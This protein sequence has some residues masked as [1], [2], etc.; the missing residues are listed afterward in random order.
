MGVSVGQT[1]RHFLALQ[2]KPDRITK[3]PWL[4]Y[5]VKEKKG[6]ARETSPVTMGSN[7]LAIKIL[8]NHTQ[9]ANLLKRRAEKLNNLLHTQRVLSRLN[10]Y[11]FDAGLDY[12]NI[13]VKL[14]N[15]AMQRSPRQLATIT[16]LLR[17]HAVFSHLL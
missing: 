9:T 8:F 10:S 1:R 3:K 11:N 16:D 2:K 15:D 17:I 13:T 5:N 7:E 12:G 14:L 6:I 4:P